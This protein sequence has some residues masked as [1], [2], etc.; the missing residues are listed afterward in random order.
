MRTIFTVFYLV[1]VFSSPVM[2]DQ[3]RS[4]VADGNVTVLI[5]HRFADS[6]YPST[7]VSRERFHQQMAWLLARGYRVIGLDNLV[8][9][10]AK[11]ERVSDKAVVITID[12]GYRSVF[13][14]ARPVLR[15]FGYPYTVFVYVKAVEKGYGD[16]MSWD[17][18]RQLEKE[19]VI[20]GNHSFS[21]ARMNERPAGMGDEE[22]RN[23]ISSDLVKSAR[24]M[25]KRLGDS[26]RFFA[27]PYGGYNDVVLSEA[28][29]AGYDAVL[30][31]DPGSV[32]SSTDRFRIPREPIL[33]KDWSSMKHFEKV[34]RQVDLP[35]GGFSPPL[36]PVSAPVV[37]SAQVI[38]PQLYRPGD[39]EM[40][41]SELGWKKVALDGNRLGFDFAGPFTR[42][43]NRVILKGRRKSGE[44]AM[45]T[46]FIGPSTP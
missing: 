22:Y 8:D 10:L 43:F 6:R 17:Q 38:E 14:V 40:Y 31:Q 3:P 41:V 5:Y 18:L 12:D 30:T 39:F 24:V 35:L 7:S 9:T 4:A 45:S 37:F 46:W 26:P 44:V 42:K 11:G 13:E 29:K 28:K 1:V 34:V 21:H 20:I 25:M 23:W 33:G 2:A 32:S 15:S 19:G 27:I 16:F 36:G